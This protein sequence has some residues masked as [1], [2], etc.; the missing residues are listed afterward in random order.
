MLFVDIA[1][2]GDHVFTS[3]PQ[4]WSQS[5]DLLCDLINSSNRIK[6]IYMVGS[7]FI[8]RYIEVTSFNMLSLMCNIVSDRRYEVSTCG[9]LMH[10]VIGYSVIMS[11]VIVVWS[12][13]L[14]SATILEGF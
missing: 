11:V 1:P 14:V 2:T 9:Y 8:F 6:D 10:I 5:H 13:V 12:C 4:R 3:H 7:N